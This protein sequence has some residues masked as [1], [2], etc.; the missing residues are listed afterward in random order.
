MCGRGTVEQHPGFLRERVTLISI[1][2]NV[3]IIIFDFF[4]LVSG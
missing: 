2:S 4:L 1:I 3:V